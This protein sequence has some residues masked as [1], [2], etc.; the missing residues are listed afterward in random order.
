MKGL[1]KKARG[2]KL[3]DQKAN[4]V[5]D[6][7]AV[8]EKMALEGGSVASVDREAKREDRVRREKERLERVLVRRKEA[9]NV[10][11]KA[12]GE[13]VEKAR[14]TYRELKKQKMKMQKAL[15]AASASPVAEVDAVGVDGLPLATST[16]PT[17]APK[18]GAAKQKP[19]ISADGVKIQWANLLDAEYAAT[20]PESVVH[21]V[22]P[23][24]GNRGRYM[25]ASVAKP[26][27]VA[28]E[29]AGIG[30][31]EVVPSAKSQV[32]EVPPTQPEMEA[33]EPK[34]ALDSIVRRLQFG[35]K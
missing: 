15:A 6:L 21:D 26:A 14:E 22:M 35:S 34:G 19:V 32:Q 30:G 2:K 4:S 10:L 18:R 29:I 8:L 3:R 11:S 9:R 5:A 16:R 23:H 13:E 33:P 28:A 24:G 7:A 12:K 25:A 17:A 27:Q 31:G 20:W 1:S